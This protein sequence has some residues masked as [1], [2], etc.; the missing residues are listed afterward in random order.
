[1]TYSATARIGDAERY[2]RMGEYIQVIKGL[3]TDPDFKFNGTYYRAHV[4]AAL[5]GADGKVVMP[6]PGEI[7]AKAVICHTR[8]SMPPAVRRK[9]RR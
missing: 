5:T 3:W 9:A 8:R 4:R 2:P 1:M 6:E 7:V